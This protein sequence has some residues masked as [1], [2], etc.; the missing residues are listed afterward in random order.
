[1]LALLS[2][3]HILE[4]EFCK[5]FIVVQGM[6]TVSIVLLSLLLLFTAIGT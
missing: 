3:K 2:I 4:K 6:P 1:M 5:E